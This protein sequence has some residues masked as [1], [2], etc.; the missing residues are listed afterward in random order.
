MPKTNSGPE[1]ETDATRWEKLAVRDQETLLQSLENEAATF[2]RRAKSQGR[3]SEAWKQREAQ[4]A[5][6]WRAAVASLQGSRPVANGDAVALRQ[7]RR[8]LDKWLSQAGP[9]HP[10]EDEIVKALDVIVE[11]TDEAIREREA[12]RARPRPAST[13]FAPSVDQRQRSPLL[14]AL[15]ERS[16]SEADAIEALLRE[17]ERLRVAAGLAPD[18]VL[19]HQ[20]T[21][22]NRKT[23]W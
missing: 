14:A 16:I 7:V 13:L 10:L 15:A 22:P 2:E 5:A 4:C 20:I 17:N 12:Q 9:G 18:E 8:H 23:D 21:S 6:I 3:G 19:R 1:T 11:R